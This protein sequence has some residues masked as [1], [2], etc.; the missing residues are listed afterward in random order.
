LIDI[1]RRGITI[2]RAPLA[3][4]IQ[5]AGFNVEELGFEAI[6]GTGQGD[7]ISPAIWTAVFDILLS[8]LAEAQ[9]GGLRVRGAFGTVE[10][11]G[12]VAYADDLVSIQATA[13]SL[14]AKADLVSGFCIVMGLTLATDKFRA[15]AVNWG[16]AYRRIGT[17]I[18]IH[19][20]GW[21]PHKVQLRSDGVYKHL[22]IIWDMDL[23]N[24]TQRQQT[25][26]Y[27]KQS[28]AYVSARRASADVKILAITKSIIPKTVFTA[29]QMA[30]TLD[31]Y[32]AMDRCVSAAYRAATKNL[33]TFPT[34]LLYLAKRLGGLGLKAE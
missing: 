13:A 15:F 16:N 24:E 9:E 20:L 1:D 31:E 19:G 33:A 28:L 30:W 27:L 25:L 17:H 8:A 4:A 18:M 23:T 29:R 2:L 21:V 34:E 3:L 32:I 7:V 14:Q 11:V 10:R 5:R 22:G 12:D 6:R 26:T